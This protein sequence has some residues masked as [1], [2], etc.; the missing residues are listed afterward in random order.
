MTAVNPAQA[1]GFLLRAAAFALLIAVATD[2]NADT[3]LWGH[4]GPNR[5]SEQER[6]PE[7]R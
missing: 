5:V 1:A 2:T 7:V 6:R 3:D 4:D